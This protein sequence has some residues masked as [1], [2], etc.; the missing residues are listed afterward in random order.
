MAVEIGEEAPDFLLPDSEGSKTKLSD[1]RGKKNVLLVF[2]PLAFSPV[3]ST[4]FCMFRDVNSD[5][6]GG[7]T[8]VLGISVD[9]VWTLRA[10]KKAE[11]Y[12]NAFLSDF[13]PHG[14][15]S[16]AYGAFLEERGISL[17]ATFLID[18]EGVVR[19]KEINQPRDARDQAGWRKAI[20][21]LGT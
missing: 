7:D 20:A 9:S 5:I 21:E 19:W 16:R 18:K 1:Y 11:G 10:W 15:I 17:R 3:C 14:E 4:E 12:P 2:Y 13:W 6:L 8:E